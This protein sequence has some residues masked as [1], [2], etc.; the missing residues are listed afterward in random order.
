MWNNL[1]VFLLF[2]QCLPLVKCFFLSPEP[3]EIAKVIFEMPVEN[4]SIDLITGKWISLGD[5]QQTYL[6][7][8]VYLP[9]SFLIYEVWL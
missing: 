2:G 7:V 4:D 9:G 8:P 1:C 5:S 3:H 6:G